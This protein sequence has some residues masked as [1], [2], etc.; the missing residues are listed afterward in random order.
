MA[1]VSRPRISQFLSITATPSFSRIEFQETVVGG[2][3]MKY[4]SAIKNMDESDDMVE[5]GQQK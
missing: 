2:G 4:E 1:N 3:W 5:A